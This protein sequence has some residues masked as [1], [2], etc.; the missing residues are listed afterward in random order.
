M[1]SLSLER[2]ISASVVVGPYLCRRQLDRSR[3]RAVSRRAP[4]RAVVDAEL[5]ELPPDMRA[6]RLVRIAGLIASVG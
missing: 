3:P 4:A 5:A 6:A 1:L 2:A